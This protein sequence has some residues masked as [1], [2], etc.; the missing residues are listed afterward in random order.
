MPVRLAIPL[1]VE[2]PH[3]VRPAYVHALLCECLERDLAPTHHHANDKPFAI[4]PLRT[5][6][7]GLAAFEVG[8][9]DDGLEERLLVALAGRCGRLRLGRQAARMAGMPE[10]MARATWSELVR[11]AVAR[12]EYRFDFVT[13]TVFRNERS[14]VPLPLPGSIFG[15]Y[16]SRWAA[17][18][19]PELRPD[20]AFDELGLLVAGLSDVATT[21]FPGNA[22]RQ[23]GFTGRVSL[24]LKDERSGM[25]AALDALAAIADYSGTG[26]GTPQGMGV[27]RYLGGPPLD[28]A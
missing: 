24:T 8:L 9:L 21:H 23:I 6:R 28:R 7:D 14:S 16:R 27:T 5:H 13:A 17:F 26:S 20:V 12:R 3:L 18:A 15:H 19:P 1:E 25:R 10:E 11:G 2:C 22:R 4:S